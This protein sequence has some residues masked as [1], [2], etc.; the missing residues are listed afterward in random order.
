MFPVGFALLMLSSTPTAPPGLAVAAPKLQRG[1]ELVYVGEI[2]ESSD[3]PDNRYKKKHLLEVRLFVLD[4]A[5]E[6]S[7]CA[8][9]TSLTTLPDDAVAKAVLV[10]SGS[11]PACPWSCKSWQLP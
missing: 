10:V 6:S 8:I 9:M 11:N 4:T 7:D 1:D 3:R 5:A 2:A